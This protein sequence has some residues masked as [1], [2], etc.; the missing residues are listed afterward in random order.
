MTNMNT[1]QIETAIQKHISSVSTL[2]ELESFLYDEDGNEYPVIVAVTHYVKQ[3]P[4][5]NADS[6]DDY[7]GYTE[8][9]YELFDENGFEN[10][11]LYSYA[12]R[13]IEDSWLEEHAT[14][15]KDCYEDDKAEA[16]L[17]AAEDYADYVAS[18]YY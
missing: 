1:N 14:Y 7:Y 16:A 5:W 12:T 13:E 10:E 2:N 4:L 3:E 17:Q 9:D 18:N 15:V 11:R 6:S 8:F